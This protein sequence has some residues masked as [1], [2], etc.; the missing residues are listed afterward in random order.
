MSE[1]EEEEETASFD[2]LLDLDG[3]L[4]GDEESEPGLP[5]QVRAILF[6]GRSDEATWRSNRTSWLS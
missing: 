5:I 4:P 6:A 1:E 2:G 3:D